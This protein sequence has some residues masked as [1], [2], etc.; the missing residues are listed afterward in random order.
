MLSDVNGGPA[1][2]RAPL[3]AD[4]TGRVHV[5]GEMARD[6]EF[7]AAWADREARAVLAVAEPE[8]SGSYQSLSW[9]GDWSGDVAA[10]VSAFVGDGQ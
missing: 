5:H 1:F 10:L 2:T 6:D 7:A 9:L 4:V 8:G 3:F